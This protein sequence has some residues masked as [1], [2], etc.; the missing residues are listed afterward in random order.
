MRF[1]FCVPSLFHLRIL[2]NSA[3]IPFAITEYAEQSTDLCATMLPYKLRLRI[4]STS[5]L[6]AAKALSK[7]RSYQATINPFHRPGQR[8]IPFFR[9]P[10]VYNGFAMP[11]VTTTGP[12]TI[13]L[14]PFYRRWGIIVLVACVILSIAWM[15]W[16]G[17]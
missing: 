16:S 7:S 4:P 11:V 3:D 1:Y 9:V 13:P 14:F 6:R 15:H 12:W 10:N 5:D 17:V 2:P 8:S